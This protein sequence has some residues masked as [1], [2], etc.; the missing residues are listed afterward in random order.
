MLSKRILILIIPI[1]LLS[2]SCNKPAPPILDS[3][4]DSSIQEVSKPDE[5]EYTEI[6]PGLAPSG[7]LIMPEDF[8]YLGFFRLP[9]P[10]GGSDWEYSGHGLTYY[11]NGDPE[12][13]V[14][15]F[16]GSLFGFGH[17]H[18]LFVSEI[19]IPKP[20]IAANLEEINTAQTLQPFADLSGGIFSAPEMTI[21]RAGLVYLGEPEPRLYFAFGEHLQDFEP[22]HGWSNLDLTDVDAQSPWIFG[23]F[24]N[25]VTNDYLFEIPPTWAESIAPG[26]LLASGR[27]R[28]GLWSGRGPALFAYHP[29]DV[30]NPLPPDST[31]RGVIPLL[32]YGEQLPGQ[33]DLISSPSQAVID[34]READHW[35]GGEWLTVGDS[36]AVVFAGTKALGEE[37]YGFANGLVW[38]HDCAEHSPPTCPN[39]PEWPYEDRGFWA[40]DYQAQLIFYNPGQLVAVAQGDLESW[41]PQPYAVLVLD[42]FLLDPSLD[43]AEY[44]RDLVGAVAFDRENRLFY[45]VERLADEYRSVIHVWRI[46]S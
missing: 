37:W 41:Q 3:E 18:Q 43:P 32:L 8:T 38:E 45:L 19:S 27:A 21:P 9:E 6:Y 11:P 14:D 12:G 26:P 29:G 36:A 5:S 40:E 15:G 34:Y 2:L 30:D 4:E 7:N 20:A 10:S 31:L 22:S 16:P 39:P 35:W 33:P 1:I 25:Y 44:K 13:P 28:E 42:D 24:T 23:E 46:D 17:D